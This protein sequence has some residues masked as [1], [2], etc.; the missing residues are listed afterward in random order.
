VHREDFIRVTQIG[1]LDLDASR[2]LHREIVGRLKTTGVPHV[3]IDM[4]RTAPGLRLTNTDLFEL[5][6][7]SGT[8]LALAQGRIACRFAWTKRPTR[9]SSNRSPEGRA[10]LGGHSP[11]SSLPF[12]GS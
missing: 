5:G 6:V 4:R 11:H 7:A 8:Q 1:T 3:L 9:S 2:A 10:P 12:R